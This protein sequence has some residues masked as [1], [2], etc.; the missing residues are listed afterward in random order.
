MDHTVELFEILEGVDPEEIPQIP[1]CPFDSSL[2]VGPVRIAKM[3]GKPE[4]AGEVH[5]LVIELQLGGSFNHHGFEVVIP[6]SPGNASHLPI[7]LQM[8]L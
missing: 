3:N 6:V 2:L 1:Q 5:K 7:G 8:T 4:V